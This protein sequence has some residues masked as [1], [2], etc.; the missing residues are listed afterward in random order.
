MIP[1]FI[2]SRACELGLGLIAITDHNASDNAAAVM[3]AAEGT[4]VQ[5]L[6]GMELQTREEVH[7]LCLFDNLNAC[8][9]WHSLVKGK[10]PPLNN[11][12]EFFGPQFVVDSAGDLLRT[13]ERLL[14]TA[15]DIGLEEAIVSIHGLGG[16]AIPAH[17]DRPSFS[18]LAN[19]GFIPAGFE[20]DGLEVSRQFKPPDGGGKWPQLRVWP[21]VMDGD[22]HRLQDMQKCTRFCVAA[23]VIAELA[24]ALKGREGRQMRVEW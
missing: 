5:V 17:V 24:M 14:A 16:L 22:A 12:E 20:A 18:L 7:L 23:P 19:L 9:Q 21:L 8:G 13:E 10:L 2:V 1:P 4:G 15:A 11:R 6:P 3:A